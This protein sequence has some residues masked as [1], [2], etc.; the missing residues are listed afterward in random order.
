MSKYKKLNWELTSEPV[1]GI[2]VSMKK[3]VNSEDLVFH[4]HIFRNGKVLQSFSYLTSYFAEDQEII[5]Q[6]ATRVALEI[7]NYA[8]EYGNPNLRHRIYESSLEHQRNTKIE[9]YSSYN[10]GFRAAIE[11]VDRLIKD[12]NRNPN[13]EVS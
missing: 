2:F 9:P 1:P 3:D 8:S 13:S 10:D 5:D 4:S 12:S 11:M 6:E 7:E